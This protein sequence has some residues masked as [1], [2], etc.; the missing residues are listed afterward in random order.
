MKCMCTCVIETVGNMCLSN[1]PS[2]AAHATR[3]QGSKHMYNSE[4]P[5]TQSMCGSAINKSQ[6][7][8][9]KLPEKPSATPH[10]C[11]GPRYSELNDAGG[12]GNL[13]I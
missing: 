6:N 3:M 9:T 11:A 7:H 4:P 2:A 10:V 8:T 13:D 1:Y 5:V 12:G